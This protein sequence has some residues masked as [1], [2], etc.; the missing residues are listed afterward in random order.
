MFSLLSI[1][2]RLKMFFISEMADLLKWVA[3]SGSN[4][5]PNSVQGDAESYGAALYIGRTLHHGNWYPGKCARHLKGCLIL[6]VSRM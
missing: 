2:I 6:Y 4:I 5:P 1:N 3:S